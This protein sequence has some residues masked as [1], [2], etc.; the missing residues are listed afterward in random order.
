LLPAA[1]L[2]T[3][4][5]AKS[6]I[7]A[8]AFNLLGVALLEH[9]EGTHGEGAISCRAPAMSASGLRP[10]APAV[11]SI[12]ALAFDL[13]AIELLDIGGGIQGLGVTASS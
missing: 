11:G 1:E 2:G 12:G 9:A 4:A 5:T 13:L 6:S 10:W 8:R 7:G 3:N